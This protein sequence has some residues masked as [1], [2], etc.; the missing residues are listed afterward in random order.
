MPLK[1]TM[2]NPTKQTVKFSMDG[3]PGTP[4]THYAVDPGDTVELLQ[5]YVD[6]GCIGKIAA[7]LVPASTYTAPP[8]P[9]A[10]PAP[11]KSRFGSRK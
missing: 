1:I 10:A 7:G 6:S 5:A 11:K 3:V 4:T 9:K 2:V 8:A